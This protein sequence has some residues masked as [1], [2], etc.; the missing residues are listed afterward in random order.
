AK[1]PENGI[2]NSIAAVTAVDA[3][4]RKQKQLE[5]ALRELNNHMELSKVE[6]I[7]KKTHY[8][9]TFRIALNPNFMC[10]DYERE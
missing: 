6:L 2:P 7:T 5:E 1:K 10:D 9:D 3:I 8:N 4:R